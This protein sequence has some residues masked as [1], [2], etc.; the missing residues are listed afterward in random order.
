MKQNSI[1]ICKYS[2]ARV[3]YLFKALQGYASSIRICKN[4]ATRDHPNY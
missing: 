2:T 4:A 1:K 3:E